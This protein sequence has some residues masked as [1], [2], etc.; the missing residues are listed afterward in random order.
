M[1]ETYAS[2]EFDVT[3]IS[4]KASAALPNRPRALSLGKI[5]RKNL[6]VRKITGDEERYRNRQQNINITTPISGNQAAPR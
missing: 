6:L 2:D 3:L 1:D 4:V 5:H